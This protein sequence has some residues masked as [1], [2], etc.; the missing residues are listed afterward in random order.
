MTLVHDYHRMAE[1]ELRVVAESV[2]LIRTV[3]ED[4]RRVSD[5][6]S[7]GEVFAVKTVN[8]VAE[9]L[10]LR[11]RIAFED[12]EQVE[13][14]PGLV[15]QVVALLNY[16]GDVRLVKITI[17]VIEADQR[18]E[19]KTG[20]LAT[21]QRENF[22]TIEIVERIDRLLT[23]KGVALGLDENPQV[24]FG[25]LNDRQATVDRNS[26]DVTGGLILFRRGQ[27]FGIVDGELLKQADVGEQVNV[28]DTD[29]GNR[30]GRKL[31]IDEVKHF[32]QRLVR[33]SRL[34]KDQ[35]VLLAQVAFTRCHQF[36]NRPDLLPLGRRI[37]QL[38]GIIFLFQLVG[39]LT[40]HAM[41]V[42]PMRELKLYLFFDNLEHGC[43]C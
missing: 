1:G 42:M 35:E 14:L 36:K 21:D 27:S 18:H 23:E 25:F 30:V 19:I 31:V 38:A 11:F 40:N 8:Y 13:A 5:S 28:L 39:D 15:K 3:A 37:S 34:R 2:C 17:N 41:Q 16:R 29:D 26:V 4:C 33:Q 6:R 22:T 12:T 10:V 9:S 43:L 32:R 24:I 20:R 7:V